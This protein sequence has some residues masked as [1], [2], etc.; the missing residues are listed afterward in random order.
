MPF[1]SMHVANT[2]LEKAFAEDVPIVPGKLQRILWFTDRKALESDV[3]YRQ[4][5]GFND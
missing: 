3:S 1:A 5:L 2:I 4:V